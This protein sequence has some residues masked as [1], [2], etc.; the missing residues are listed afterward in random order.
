MRVLLDEN[1]PHDLI[2]QLTGHDVVTV[3]GLG[4][5]GVKNGDLLG[6][7]AGLIDVF[8]TMDRRLEREHDLTLLPF[9][10][11]VL[12]ARSNRVQDLLPLLARILEALPLVKPGLVEHVGLDGRI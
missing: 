8:L 9:G 11:I 5:A 12:L 7:A 6:R 4:W 1:L 10:V 2:A 3:Q